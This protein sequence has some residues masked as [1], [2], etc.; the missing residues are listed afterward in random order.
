MTRPLSLAASV[1]MASIL[2]A[3]CVQH[4]RTI[5][6]T[7][8][9]P[10]PAVP[11][12][13]GGSTS[14]PSVVGV[15]TANAEAP[16][17]PSS[18]TCN[19]FQFQIASQTATSVAGTF[20]ATCGNGL[21]VSGSANGQLNG[22]NVNINV[23]GSGSMSGLPLCPFS[24]TSTGTVEDNGNT[25]VLPYS[26]T[27]CFGPVH[28]TQTLHR[29][30]APAP[31]PEPVPT[32]PPPPPPPPSPSGPSDAIDLRS[33]IITGNSAQDVANWPITTAITGMDFRGDGVRVDFSKKDGA[34]RWPDVVPPGW[35]GPLQYTLWMVVNIN[36]RW[37]TAGG[38]EY[39]YGLDR[40]GGPPSQFTRNWYYSDLMW[41]PLATHQP[42][43]GEQVGFFIT[44]G[45]E[46]VKDV[47]LVKERSQVVMVSF[48]SDNA[49]FYGFSLS[50]TK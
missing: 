38:V 20:T 43:V 42:G 11:G 14:S 30:Q 34:G 7:A 13:S 12:S 16:A 15:W 44:A 22:N 5:G 2:A 41:G 40:Q 1:A 47:T 4:S 28:G 17:L 46:R 25:L 50:R 29:P 21:V 32:T 26:G 9:T 31:A 24:L 27:T 19:N 33:A 18:S 10:T 6:E 37:Y 23:N 8:P 3:G 48:P 36:G 49:G 45:D 35:D 39:W